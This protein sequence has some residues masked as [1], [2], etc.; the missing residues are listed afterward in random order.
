MGFQPK[1][2]NGHSLF[3]VVSA[4]QKAVRR[5]DVDDALYWAVDMDLSGYSEYCWRR[6]QIMASE[7]IGLANPVAPAIV[8]ALR[9]TYLDHVGRSPKHAPERLMLINAVVYLATSPKSRMVD[10]ALIA[11]Y[12]NHESLYRE[13][14]DYALDKHTQRGK[15]KKRGV[16][17]FY[18]EGASIRPFVIDSPHPIAEAIENGAD[19]YEQMARRALEEGREPA[20]PP[21]KKA[22]PKVRTDNPN[23]CEHSDDW[24]DCLICVGERENK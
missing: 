23:A 15:A 6:L 1:T 22:R 9:E 13:I 17:H 16:A 2:V 5:G 19:P 8:H 14:P 4:L 12:A 10:N 24:R 7:D 18:D 11:H 20:L 3:E 21:K